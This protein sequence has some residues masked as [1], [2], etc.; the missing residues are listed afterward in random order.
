MKTS[1][2]YR[3][4]RQDSAANG[5]VKLDNGREITACIDCSREGCPLRA[6]NSWPATT[7]AGGCPLKTK[8]QE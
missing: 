7:I 5:P 1:K 4:C 2:D 8:R 3:R 6:R